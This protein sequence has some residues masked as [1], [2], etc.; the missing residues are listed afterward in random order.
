MRPLSIS[1]LFLALLPTV[2]DAEPLKTWD[3][4]HSIESIEVT[5]VY[6]VPNDGK[7][8]P[9]WRERVAYFSRRIEQFHQ[10]EY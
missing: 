9:D 3:G 6:F 10:R 1:W 2:V 8:L 5:V 4:R 7:P